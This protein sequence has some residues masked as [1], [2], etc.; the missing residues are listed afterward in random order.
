DESALS[1]T[2]SEAFAMRLLERLADRDEVVALVLEAGKALLVDRRAERLQVA[3]IGRP[4][5]RLDLGAGI[6]DVVFAGD[7]EARFLQQRGQRIADHRAPTM[8]DMHRPG[9][10][11]RDIFD[12]HL[13]PAADRGI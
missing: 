10:I 6:V 12:I 13:A 4:G 8:A 5:E 7:V 9:R 2:F 3:E 11:G 1:V